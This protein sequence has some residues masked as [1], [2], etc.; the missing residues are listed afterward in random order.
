MLGHG[1]G[2]GCDFCDALRVE[3][4]DEADSDAAI[5]EE[6]EEEDRS[7]DAGTTAETDCDAR[8]SRFSD[9]ESVRAMR[10]ESIIRAYARPASTTATGIAYHPSTSYVGGYEEAGGRWEQGSWGAGAGAGGGDD[11]ERRASEWARSY[12][13]LVGRGSERWTGGMVR[14]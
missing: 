3:R 10:E 4:A 7:T 6:E 11:A 2:E 12:E 5:E 1:P 8:A 14:A 13:G 9:S